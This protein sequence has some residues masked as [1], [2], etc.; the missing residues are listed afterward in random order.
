MIDSIRQTI[1]SGLGAAVVTQEKLRETLVALLDRGDITRDQMESILRA[2]VSEGKRESRVIAG[3]IAREFSRILEASPVV[4]R[5][6]FRHLEARLRALE[7]L[8]GGRAPE[9]VEPAE[10]PPPG[11]SGDALPADAQGP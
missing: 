10:G 8:V 5:R 3:R 1:L 7:A 6:E 11:G 2:V 4:T 9:E